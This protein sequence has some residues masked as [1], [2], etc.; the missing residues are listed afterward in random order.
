MG[1][2]SGA[3]RAYRLYSL[4][5]MSLFDIMKLATEVYD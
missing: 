2:Q 4:G 5:L 1:G 3:T